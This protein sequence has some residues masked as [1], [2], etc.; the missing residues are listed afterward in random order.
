MVWPIVAPPTQVLLMS[1]ASGH[2]H[3]STIVAVLVEHPSLPSATASPS[4][5]ERG[6]VVI[7]EAASL[8]HFHLA[9]LLHFFAELDLGKVQT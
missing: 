8:Q 2:V 9:H 1:T 3:I 6:D 7:L 5:A 4:L